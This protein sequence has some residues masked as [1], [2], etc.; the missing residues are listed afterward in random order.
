MSYIQSYKS[1]FC[2]VII[3]AFYA[4]YFKDDQRVAKDNFGNKMVLKLVYIHHNG[5]CR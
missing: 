5:D 1:K 3:V 2:K 4:K